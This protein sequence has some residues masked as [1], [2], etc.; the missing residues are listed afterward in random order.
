MGGEVTKHRLVPWTV[1]ILLVLVV[2]FFFVHGL[3]KSPAS[4]PQEEESSPSAPVPFHSSPPEL[5]DAKTDA[6]QRIAAA[7]NPK[8]MDFQKKI[9]DCLPDLTW[10]NIETADQL[11][12]SEIAGNP[13][14]KLE[15][16]MENTHIELPDGSLRRIQLIPSEK[17]QSS[18]NSEL[19]Y[20]KLDSEGLPERIP[21]SE[22][23][24]Y[25]PSKEI[26]EA[27][28]SQG[29]VVFHQ[30]KQHQWLKDGTQIE[31]NEVDGRVFE[32]QI[33]K[34]DKTLSCRDIQCVC[35]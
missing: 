1:L 9:H 27:L 3:A 5:A 33:A 14:Q 19:R 35:R 32:I 2:W 21:L 6:P 29:R 20:F 34:P 10:V 25:R 26:I 22:K 24:T 31:I 12:K 28:K 18:K 11:L 16:E 7:I 4:T 13:V 15:F 8:L 23:E 30:I 17:V